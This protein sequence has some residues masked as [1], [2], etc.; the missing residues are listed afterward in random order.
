MKNKI[1]SFLTSRESTTLGRQRVVF[2]LVTAFFSFF[3]SV[4]FMIMNQ[5]RTRIVVIVDV[6]SLVL[7]LVLV[8]LYFGKRLSIRSVS[9]ILYI[10]LQVEISSQMI[11][12][13]TQSTG[14][15]SA[16]LIQESFLSLLLIMI[17][18]VANL[19]YCPAV[20]SGISIVTYFVCLFLSREPALLTFLP[21]YLVVL[22]GV[23]IYDTLAMR[24]AQLLEAEN[25]HLKEEL[26]DFMRITG[27]TVEDFREIIQLSEG[28]A[29]KTEKTR[30]LLNSMDAR[31]R[32][33][34]VGGVLAV[35]AQN[36]SSRELLLT[37]FPELTPSQISIAQLI[38]QDK[39]LTEICRILG[40]TENNVSAQRSK[41]RSVLGIESEVSLKEALQERLDAYLLSQER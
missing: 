34:I 5:P 24:G 40:K 25:L 3:I 23:I 13:C 6:V 2:F 31:V 1:Q 7:T 20:I 37:V 27:L 30:I 39:K 4:G 32:E 18:I 41:I 12:L 33:N 11:S 21:V 36:D 9:N 10:L 22:V 19:K 17:S 38:L 14:A 29:N 16:L 28:S 8:A 15:I 35:K 26:T